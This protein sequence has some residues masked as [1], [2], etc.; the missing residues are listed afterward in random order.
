MLPSFRLIAATFLCGFFVVFAG[1]RLAASLNDIHEGLPVMAAHAAPV[2]ITPVADREARRGLSSVPVMYDMRFAVSPVAPTLIRVAPTLLDRPSSP[3]AIAP[4]ED[5]TKESTV[6]AIQTDAPA[7]EAPAVIQDAPDEAQAPKAPAIAAIDSQAKHGV[8]LGWPAAEAP[9]AAVETAAAPA[10]KDASV[11]QQ[12]AA[13]PSTEETLT[14]PEPETPAAEPPPAEVPAIDSP[15]DD[16]A[17][18][19]APSAEASPEPAVAPQPATTSSK[20]AK[21]VAKK[22]H[23][24]RA[25]RKAPKTAKPAVVAPPLAAAAAA[26]PRAKAKTARQRHIRTAARRVVPTATPFGTS[27]GG[28]AVP[29]IGA[30]Q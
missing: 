29:P 30:Q 19:P 18:V 22:R 14:S 1:L 15:A 21:P 9:A 8:G 10:A 17:A 13:L 5:V 25:A 23:A 3:L 24:S 20:G 28:F 6:A 4:S 16:S 26:A 2:S 27:S 12:M 7:A 11:E